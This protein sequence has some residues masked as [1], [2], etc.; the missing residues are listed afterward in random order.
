MSF[1]ALLISQG[2]HTPIKLCPHFQNGSLNQSI[3]VGITGAFANPP[4]WRDSNIY[5]T[6]KK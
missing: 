5:N 3:R 2:T 6:T 4:M 1:V